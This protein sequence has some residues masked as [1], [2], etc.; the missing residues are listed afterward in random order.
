[1]ETFL[2]SCNA[3]LSLKYRFTVDKFLQTMGTIISLLPRYLYICHFKNIGALYDDFLYC[4]ITLATTGLAAYFS[5]LV[6]FFGLHQS[7]FWHNCV[8]C[9][10]E[11]AS[12]DDALGKAKI[13]SGMAVTIVV[14][15]VSLYCRIFW[16]KKTMQASIG[17]HEPVV[18]VGQQM[19]PASEV[20]LAEHMSLCVFTHNS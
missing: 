7:P 1:M 19:D 12:R 8:A 13:Y 18:I 6:S 5:G 20:G 17:D 9:K 4:F 10:T 15:H 14:V 16:H 2:K 11:A 3:N